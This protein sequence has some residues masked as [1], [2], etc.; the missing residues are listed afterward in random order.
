M[1]TLLLVGKKLAEEVEALR[2]VEREGFE[3]VMVATAA[4]ALEVARNEAPA[5]V[6]IEHKIPD[7]DGV[8]LLKIMRAR[9]PSTEAVLVTPGGE[10]EPAIEVLRAGALDYLQFPIDL[11][12]LAVSLGRAKERRLQNPAGVRPVILVIEDHDPSRESL[13]R[14]L[15]KEGYGVLAASD[16]MDGMAIFESKRVDIIV[17]DLSMPRMGGLEVLAKTKG[18]GADVEVLVM[19]GYGDEQTVVQALRDGAINFL[20]K[21]IDIDQMLLAIEKAVEFQAARR[22]LLY[23]NRDVELMH[24][25][26]VRLT[27]ELE[28]IVETQ[29]QLSNDTVE[30]LRRFV[31]ALPVGVLVADEHR[32]AVYANRHVAGTFGRDDVLSAKRLSEIGACSLSDD[33]FETAFARALVSPPGTIE[34]VSS[35]GSAFVVVTSIKTVSHLGDERYVAVLVRGEQYADGQV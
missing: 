22:S 11:Q 29:G 16:G 13:V 9:Y 30:Y 19:T 15:K 14:I 27:L 1:T 28:L 6:L 25:L 35:C 4:E 10:V 31:D 12:Q 24:Q 32:R 3:P 26:V 17:L 33:A 21:P 2:L 8:E 7:G 18:A 5:V 23:R 20:R 34:T